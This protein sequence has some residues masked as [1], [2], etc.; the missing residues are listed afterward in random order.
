MIGLSIALS[1]V[2]SVAEL[3]AGLMEWFPA[4]AIEYWDLSSLDRAEAALESQEI[5]TAD[6]LFQVDYNRSEFPMVVHID[7]FPGPH[8]DAVTG[9]TMIELARMFAAAFGC[10]AF[11]DGSGYVGDASPYWAIMWDEGRSFLADLCDTEFLD[12]TGGLVQIVREIPL[13]SFEL[14]ESGQPVG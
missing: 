3:R 13:P 12:E 5:A 10:R 9:P 11:T 4:L 1:V 6:V 7:K 2:R 14:D 8:D